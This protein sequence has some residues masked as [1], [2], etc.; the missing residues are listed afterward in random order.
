MRAADARHTE[1]LG[2]HYRHP[3]LAEGRAQADEDA[4]G[5]GRQQDLGEPRQGRA[6]A[7]GLGDLHEVPVDPTHRPLSR[8]EHDPEHADGDDEH[9]GRGLDPEPDDGEG[10]PGEA[11]NGPQQAHDPG[12]ERLEAP[13][14]ADQ[15]AERDARPCADGE[16]DEV[17]AQARQHRL[18]PDPETDLVEEG[19]R[20]RARRRQEGRVDQLEPRH[21]LPEQ[22]EGDES[23]SR[24]GGCAKGPSSDQRAIAFS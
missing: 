6:E 20:D 14:H 16:A 24:E 8:E 21:R 17:V 23:E 13:E 10:H 15:D 12:G 9:G 11:G 5:R 19:G 4:G 2:G 1:D 22:E 7:E 18:A 3:G